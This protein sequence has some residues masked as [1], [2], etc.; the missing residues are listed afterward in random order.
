MTENKIDY[1]NQSAQLA[2]KVALITGASRGIGNAICAALLANGAVVFATATSQHGQENLQAQFG[3]DYP[4]QLF[5]K[6]LDVTDAPA[7]DDLVGQIGAQFGAVDIL[8]NNAGITQDNL[9]LRMK[10]QEW[11][12]V[13]D[14]NLSG[15]YYACHAV[16][17]GMV[18][19]R[20]GVIIN[21]SSVVALMGNAGQCNYAAAKAGLIGMSKSLALELGG[22]GIRVNCIA[23]GFIATDMTKDVDEAT[24]AAHIPLKHIGSA[25]DIAHAV[26]FLAG[27]GGRYLTGVCLNISG[28]M[29][30]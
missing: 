22:R 13:L 3:A 12:Q 26:V 9:L 18:K 1:R 14:T 25:A 11:Q 8:I 28:G 7:I 24:L 10:P 30:I 16:A 20:H 19:K 27:E 5:A 15:A 29:Y 17:K 6:I 2:G 4:D 23:P 21:I